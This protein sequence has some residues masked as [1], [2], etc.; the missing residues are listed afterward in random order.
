M[1]VE[2]V[3]KE[4]NLAICDKLSKKLIKY[5]LFMNFCPAIDEREDF[6]KA[7][8]YY[9]IYEWSE[10]DT[11]I[12]DKD[13]TVL[14]TLIDPHT[15][16]YKFKGKGARGLKRYKNSKSIFTHREIVK[17]IVHIIAPGFMNPMVFSLYAAPEVDL[18]AI[19][20]VVDEAIEIANKN[21]Y[22][23]CYE[24]FSQKLIPF[25]LSK[26]FEVSYQKQYVDTRFVETLMTYRT[27]K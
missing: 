3:N 16:E 15:F 5:P 25:M 6:I 26:G 17:G 27:N 7:F 14:A 10:F 12:S 2:N 21:G 24:T 8:F 11:L 1:I 19:D 20:E 4:T 13:M 9:Y 23:L 22:T 18:E